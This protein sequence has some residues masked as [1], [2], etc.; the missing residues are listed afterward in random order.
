MKQLRDGVLNTPK[1]GMEIK[2]IYF[3]SMLLNVVAKYCIQRNIDSCFVSGRYIV[4]D[5]FSS[6]SHY[7]Q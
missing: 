7:A 5:L 1:H 2:P 4:T 6:V 3:C